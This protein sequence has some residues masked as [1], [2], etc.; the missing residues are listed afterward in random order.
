MYQQAAPVVY[1]HLFRVPYTS[2]YS[3]H[4]IIRSTLVDCTPFSCTPHWLYAKQNIADAPCIYIDATYA[5]TPW[6]EDNADALASSVDLWLWLAFV[7]HAFRP[8]AFDHFHASYRSMVPDDYS[9]D[10]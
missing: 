2:L 1:R 4:K 10:I 5:Q 3:W 7:F 6:I 8:P 9:V